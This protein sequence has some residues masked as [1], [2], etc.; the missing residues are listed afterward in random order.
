MYHLLF[1]TFLNRKGN[2]DSVS[3]YL[4]S[5]SFRIYVLEL[6][7]HYDEFVTHRHKTLLDTNKRGSNR[8]GFLVNDGGQVLQGRQIII[9]H[10]LGIGLLCSMGGKVRRRGVASETF[11]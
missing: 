2:S 1:E 4:R 11:K 10:R 6:K 3:T 9:N 8:I 5:Y 7:D